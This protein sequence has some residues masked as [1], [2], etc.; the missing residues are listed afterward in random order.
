MTQAADIVTRLME[1]FKTIAKME[2]VIGQ[3][4][5]VDPFTIIPVTRVSL[6]LGAGDGAGKAEKS[7]GE[8]GGGGGGVMVTPLAFIVI[9]GEEIS[10]H[11]V[12][13]G[14]NIGNL[15]E[16]VPEMVEKIMAA[17]KKDKEA[18]EEGADQPES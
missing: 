16:A 18:A 10:F 5:K 17:R 9:K 8:G 3:P 6:G 2:T 13:K 1:E 12:K 14:G 11:G 7:G 15:F 4:I